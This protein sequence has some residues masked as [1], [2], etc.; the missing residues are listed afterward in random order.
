MALFF[1]NI[2]QFQFLKIWQFQFLDIW[3]FQ[4][5]KNLTILFTYY[6]TIPVFEIW[7]FQFL[8]IWQ[9]QV[10]SNLTISLFE[11]LTIPTEKPFLV[12]TVDPL[13]KDLRSKGL[14]YEVN[15]QIQLNFSKCKNHVFDVTKYVMFLFIF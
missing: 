8:N 1:L 14:K 9:F 3:H 2:L 5:L 6:L 7:Q 13:D 11:Y 4:F 12:L 10:L 15:F